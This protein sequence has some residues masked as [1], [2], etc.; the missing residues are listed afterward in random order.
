MTPTIAS[1]NL[2]DILTKYRSSPFI[3]VGTPGNHGD[4]IIHKGAEKIFELADLRYQKIG[5]Q[6]FMS[7]DAPKDSVIYING[8]GAFNNIWNPAVFD[9]FVKAITSSAKALIVGPSTFMEDHQFLNEKL[10][11]KARQITDK[12][13]F[14]FCREK[15]SYL[16]LKKIIPAQFE[17]LLDHDTAINLCAD[18]ILKDV[19]KGKHVFYAIRDDKEQFNFEKLNLLSFWIDPVKQCKTFEDWVSIHANSEKI[20]TNRLHSSILG[21][22]LGKNT[23]LLPNSYH[24]NRSVW[25]HSLKNRGVLWQDKIEISAPASLLMRSKLYKWFGNSHKVR[26][27]TNKYYGIE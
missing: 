18:D 6:E 1:K 10:F 9:E 21:L 15:T 11:S 8:N 27:L 4:S 2:F 24:K 3:F 17:L 19:P 20:V 7:F 22:I 26:K 13:V 5:D 23:T 16:T 25:E 14:I 12:K